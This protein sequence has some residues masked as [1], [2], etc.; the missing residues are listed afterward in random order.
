MPT[1]QACLLSINNYF[2]PRGGA[3]VLFLEQNRMF[4]D[5]GWQVVPFAMK[6][7]E[8]LPSPWSQYFPD[9]I[10]YGHS[11]SFAEKLVRAP[12]TIYSLQARRKIGRLLE[13]VNPRI[14][15]VHNIYHHLSP[16]ILSSLKARG[17]PVVLTI[18]DLKLTC[19]ARTLMIGS[20]PCERCRGG[21]FHHVALNRCVK[22]SL[23]LSS[24]VMVESYIHRLLQLYKSNVTR[25]VAPS[26]FI[27]EKF[28]QWGWSRDQVVYIPNFV[29]IGRFQPNAPI[30]RRFVYFGRLSKEKG[31]GTLL[32]AAAKARQPLTLVGS[33]PEESE[34]KR[35]AASLDIDVHF[36]GRQ[37]GVALAALVESARAVVVPS[38]CYENA[39]LT[40]LEGYAAGRPVIGA[41]TGGIPELVLEGRTGALFP[42]GDAEALAAT[43]GHFAETPDSQLAEMGAVGRHWVEQEF[44][45]TIYC[46]R[47]MAL[48]ES[49]CGA[50]S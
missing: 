44:S 13:R 20:Q 7:P 15:H 31:V 2:Y 21:S 29:D 1:G 6:H 3:D 5:L 11:Y 23:I 25:F 12:R 41:H 35:L 10:E 40:V 48:Y 27:L 14:A 30:G 18:H 16:S 4:E 28:L 50:V 22:G 39:P 33:G 19:P 9:E 47:V 26:R 49:L 37:H 42:T 46:N 32:R 45:S 17:I 38:E 36:A 8:N 43:L 24:M 34:L